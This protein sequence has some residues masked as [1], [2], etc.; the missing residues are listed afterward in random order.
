MPGVGCLKGRELMADV[1]KTVPFA[2]IGDDHPWPGT[3][4]LHLTCSVVDQ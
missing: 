4:M 2:T 1:R 3:S